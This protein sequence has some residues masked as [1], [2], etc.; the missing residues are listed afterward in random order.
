MPKVSVIMGIYNGEKTM[1]RAV[2]SI[3]EQTFTDWEL[4]ICD[5]CSTDNT[6][7]IALDYAEKD[8][9]I[10]V[11]QNE[12]NMRLAY[13]LNHCLS[14]ARG[15]YIAR[16]DDDD[17]CLPERFKKQV[18]YLD[19]HPEMSVVGSSVIVFNETGDIGIRGI[20]EEYPIRKTVNLS[21]PFAHPTVMMRKTVYDVLEGY[22]VSPETFRAEDLDLWYRFRLKK[23]DGYVIQEPLLKY[24]ESIEAIKKRS[25]KAAKGMVKINKKYFKQLG[26]SSKYNFLI[27]K[28]L[29]SALLPNWLMALYHKKKLKQQLFY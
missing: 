12:K 4:I 21:T 22:T 17:I 29:I 7:K 23:F 11:I 2:N 5:D 14:V 19:E 3:I 26:V 9:R 20:G 15:E 8:S 1:E 16:M 18:K 13:S 6:Y 27:Y 28:P 24:Y 25:V 10:R